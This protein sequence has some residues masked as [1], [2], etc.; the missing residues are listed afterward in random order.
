MKIGLL[1]DV[2]A[3]LPALEAVLDVAPP[4]EDWIHA[5]D[6]VG[7]GP[8]PS[9]TISVFRERGVKSIQGNHDRAAIGEFHE[10]F[11]GIPRL[12]A[13]WTASQLSDGDRRYLESLPTELDYA[14]GRV[15]VVHGAPGAPNKRLRPDDVDRGLPGDEDVLVLGHTH[16]QL[17]REFDVGT[18]VNPGS[19][20]QP[21]DGDRR[22]AFAVL[23]LETAEVTVHRISYPHE[24]IQETARSYG[25]P[26]PI[27]DAY[28]RGE[29]SASDLAG[30]NEDV[31]PQDLGPD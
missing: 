23:N 30:W 16:Q 15:H 10:G 12:M 7:Y 27:V 5:G 1:S 29:I 19:V 20:G 21:R 4:V 17:L 9:E 6:V 3:N 11:V 25:F 8:W 2:H 18:V 31:G 22:T 13:E 26:D 24:R 14:E 28:E